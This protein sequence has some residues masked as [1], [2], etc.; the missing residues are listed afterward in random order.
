VVVLPSG[1]LRIAALAKA[2]DVD[3]AMMAANIIGQINDAGDRGRSNV[4]ALSNV[5]D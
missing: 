1:I 2:D 4:V 5:I 3:I